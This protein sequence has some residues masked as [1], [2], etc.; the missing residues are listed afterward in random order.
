[1]M[2]GPAG[3]PRESFELFVQRVRTGIEAELFSLTE[4]PEGAQ[5]PLRLLKAVR[6]ALLSGGKR[7]RPIL[8][9]A[10]GEASH[11]ADAV[12]GPPGEIASRLS[13]AACAIEMIHTFSLIHDD[14]PALDD[15]DL[16]RGRSTLHVK[17]DEAT[18]IL[19]GDA[20]LNL[21]FEVMS[22]GKGPPGAWLAAIGAVA[23]AVGMEGMISGQV[24]DLEGENT[25]ADAERLYRTHALKTGALITA[26][27]EVGGILAGASGEARARLRE[28]GKHL[29]LAFQIVD[30]ILDVEGSA[31]ML[32]K[33]PGKDAKASKATFPAMWG[34]G[35]SRRRAAQCVELSC[36]AVTGCEPEIRPGHLT[37][38]AQE[39]LTRRR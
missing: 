29:G 28:Y 30:D 25:V 20:L 11:P 2:P 34:V 38:L 9:I 21:A 10:S 14:L 32:G 17:Y 6:Y 27:C 35:E 18:A 4:P 37:T 19:A 23:R 8:V 12:L 33:S 31:E 24:L 36:A 5:P 39:V 15:D 13:T 26:C 16:R 7:L 3:T 22:R 1:M